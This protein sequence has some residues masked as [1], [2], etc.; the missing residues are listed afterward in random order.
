MACHPSAVP[1]RHGR[2]FV[3]GHGGVKALGTGRAALFVHLVPVF[4]TLL[5]ALTLGERL[6]WPLF[7]SGMLVIAGVCC[8]RSRKAGPRDLRH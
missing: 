4:G 3:W 2:G 7:W 6:G 8:G 1:A 5:A